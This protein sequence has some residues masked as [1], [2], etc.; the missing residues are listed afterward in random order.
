M[1]L[2]GALDRPRARGQQKIFGLSPFVLYGV[3]AAL[4]GLGGAVAIYTTQV[5]PTSERVA[6]LQSEVDA[7]NAEIRQKEAAL[8]DRARVEAELKQAQEQ[9][10]RLER[11]F[12]DQKDLKVALLMLDRQIRETGANLRVFKPGAVATAGQTEEQTPGTEQKKSAQ[13]SAAEQAM[14]LLKKVTYD[15]EFEGT[16]PQT[17]AVLRN[18][19][20]LK[21]LLNLTNFSMEAPTTSGEDEGQVP[22]LTTKFTLEAFVPLTPEERAARKQQ[23]QEQQKKQKQ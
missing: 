9:R 14:G 7:L 3:L 23:A 19:E 2:S 21:L 13:A 12:G 22:R 11:V 8:R 6:Q 10:A 5:R 4:V 15:V 20:R 1:T 17:L 16:F 18:I